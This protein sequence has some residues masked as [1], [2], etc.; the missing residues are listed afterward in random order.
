MTMR[1]SLL[2]DGDAS[3]ASKAVQM[4]VN[5]LNK[6]IDKT[7]R[8]A[9]K[10][11]EAGK[12]AGQGASEAAK[13]I[14][15]TSQQLAGM[16]FQL[17]DIAVGL[18]SGQSP[19][20]VMMQQGSQMAQ[21]FRSGT[22]VLSALKAVG[23]GIT[24][25]ITNPLNLAVLA[26]G[27]ALTALTSFFSYLSSQSGSNAV[28][29]KHE[30]LVKR[31]GDAWDDS[32]KKVKRYSAETREGFLLDAIMAQGGL[33]KALDAQLKS[34]SARTYGGGGKAVLDSVAGVSV[35]S[36]AATGDE[37]LIRLVEN[38]R[39]AI[40]T[41]NADVQTFRKEVYA[42]GAA[43]KDA[44]FQKLANTLGDNAEEADKAQQAL[45]QNRDVVKGLQGDYQLLN[46]ATG[47]ASQG[48]GGITDQLRKLA[49]LGGGKAFA[50]AQQPFASDTPAAPPG[51][52]A[53]LLA[54][55]SGRGSIAGLAAAP[56]ELKG[57]IL[58]AAEINK[59]DADLL[60][61]LINKESAFNPKATSPVGAM[62][63]TQLMPG[64]AR[65]LG[66]R[67]PYDARESI[68]GGAKY[69]GQLQRQFSG[70][71]ELS[72]MAYNWGQG[73]VRKWQ[74]NGADP[75]QVP[76]ETRDYVGKIS[77]G[78]SLAKLDR[79]E[80]AKAIKDAEEAQKRANS[81]TDRWAKLI[82]E[83][84]NELLTR[85][86]AVGKSTYEQAR[87]NKEQDLWAKARGIYGEGL[88][89]DR[90]LHQLLTKQIG[91][92]ADAYGKLA[93]QQMVATKMKAGSEVIERQ[94]IERWDQI[95]QVGG[96][97][98]STTLQAAE[99]TRSWGG[100]FNAVAD[101]AKRKGLDLLDS[102]I[103]NLFFGQQG[104][105]NG[106]LLGG[107]TSG[108]GDLLGG[109]IGGSFANPSVP[110]Y[111]QGAA[112]AGGA[113][114]FAGGGTFTNQIITK[115]TNFRFGANQLGQMGEERPEAV[116]PL[117]N[118]M[119]VKARNGRGETSLPLTRMS[120]GSLGVD[121]AK[122]FAR[123]D[124][125][126]SAGYAS[127]GGTGNGGLVINQTFKNY[128]SDKIETKSKRNADGSVDMETVVGRAVNQHLARGGA[129]DV[130][131]GRYAGIGV[132]TERRG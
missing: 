124:A 13:G 5:D 62:G 27:V 101:A 105:N 92:Q 80:D 89:K 11:A 31:I 42:L 51:R 45:R 72:L 68:F 29:E 15:L 127:G 24:S 85:N 4:A 60:A 87:L 16:Q 18:V 61:R 74:R 78:S 94:Q 81:Q 20:T 121:M 28:L 106:G 63:L 102:V 58:E 52:G 120:D 43:S 90:K 48:V 114:L 23:G 93:E 10:S 91:E 69:F 40:S 38:F 30:E 6:L 95:R 86:E 130:L 100:T 49:A 44:N 9:A 65:E 36:I 131:T 77:G 83:S 97:I 117:T 107:L 46:Q 109:L 57:W 12:A 125:F 37:Q 50:A 59:I 34:I 115:P 82:A 103:N 98:I 39:A 22:G 110:L 104:S 35:S 19:F 41:G 71:E 79:K 1:V 116:M 123:G 67:N 47:A 88:E 99:A 17:Q 53:Q 14:A 126:G 128:G 76:E 25:F 26:S 112:F 55:W 32:A 21:S 54:D 56:Q 122:R 7:N 8:M 73:N 129:D 119:N 111:A 33:Q 64:T 70:N 118:G 108:L 3:G 132:R 113:Q 84:R 66:V 96:G 2:I 75:S